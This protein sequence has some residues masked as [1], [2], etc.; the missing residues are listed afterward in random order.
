[1][2]SSILSALNI[3]Y[4]YEWRHSLKIYVSF[5]SSQEEAR[6]KRSR[7][8]NFTAHEK[9]LLARLINKRK[10][11]IE[12]KLTDGKTIARKKDAWLLV[13]KEFNAEPNVYK[14]QF[15]LFIHCYS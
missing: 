8:P 10:D 4:L 2:V 3:Y 13:E 1:M 15:N 6:I 7:V 5:Q 11:I 12:S 9:G 14:V